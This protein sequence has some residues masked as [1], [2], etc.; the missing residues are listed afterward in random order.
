VRT[1]N[2]VIFVRNLDTANA[3]IL[4]YVVYAIDFFKNFLIYV[5]FSSQIPSGFSLGSTSDVDSNLSRPETRTIRKENRESIHSSSSS[6][7][8]MKTEDLSRKNTNDNENIRS[9]T[10]TK[11]RHSDEEILHALTPDI[12]DD[13]ET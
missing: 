3:P 7:L 12:N 10:V 2:G 6:L 13:D 1:E 5:S 4:L 9:A 8:S 11:I